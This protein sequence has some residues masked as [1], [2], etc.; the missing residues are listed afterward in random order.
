MPAC[1]PAGDDDRPLDAV[2][3]GL[4][5]EPVERAF[6]LVGDLRQGRL[7]RQGVA[8]QSGRP[9]ASQRTL[10]E[11]SED[12]LAAALPIATVDVNETWR[13]RIIRRIHIPLVALTVSVRQ[14]EVLWALLAQRLRSCGPFFGFLARVLG[15]HMLDIVVCEI[16]GLKR[17]CNPVH[18]R[19]FLRA[20][21]AW[22]GNASDG[23]RHYGA[24]IKR[25]HMNL[26]DQGFVSAQ[27]STQL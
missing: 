23:H 16:A 20:K 1:G 24:T 9:T 26:A 4:G 15:A 6:Q 19:T 25:P 13:L 2:L 11:A 27:T 14:V 22:C 10:G 3:A 12:L 5:A 7:R 8:A 21:S 17:H 18:G